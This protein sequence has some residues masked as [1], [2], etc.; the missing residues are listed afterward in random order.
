MKPRRFII[1]PGALIVLIGALVTMDIIM[2][3]AASS[4]T[5]YTV[6]EAA[7]GPSGSHTVD[8]PHRAP[9]SERTP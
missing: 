9:G 1:W 4:G 6:E 7:N 5:F 8:R 2:L 3:I